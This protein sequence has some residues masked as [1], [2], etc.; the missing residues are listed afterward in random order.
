MI[1]VA[2]WIRQNASKYD[3]ETTIVEGMKKFNK[4]RSNMSDAYRHAFSSK[5]V[6][7]IRSGKMGLTEGE[8]RAKH[9][10]MY[11]I[12]EGVDNLQDGIY[13]T[14]QQMREFCKVSPAKWRGYADSIEFEKYKLKIPGDVIYWSTP[15][16]VKKL[17]NDL[18][19]M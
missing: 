11:K 1:S 2:E 17:K 13:L 9:D 15:N 4:T 12:R 10:N 7:S 3:R 16:S 19:L 5:K 18:N 6:T 8:I 14:D